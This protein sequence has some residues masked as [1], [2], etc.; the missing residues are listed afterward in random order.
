[1]GIEIE[2][3]RRKG[4]VIALAMLLG[5]V[6]FLSLAACGPA[7]AGPTPAPSPLPSCTPAPL[8]SPRP[9]L[10]RLVVS[11]N[12]ETSLRLR[13]AYTGEEV[14]H[15]ICRPLH[16]AVWSDLQRPAYLLE[17]S[18]PELGIEERREVPIYGPE[19]KVAL[20]FP[21]I[22]EIEPLPADAEVEVDGT[23]YHGAVRL[24]YPPE[25]CPYTATVWVRAGGYQ[26]YGVDL[27]I[28]AG[29]L[30]HREIGLQ[31]VPTAL[32]TPR[33]TAQTPRPPATPRPT[34]PTFTVEERVA[35]VRQKLYESF[36]C[37]RAEN[38]LP[39]LPYVIEWQAL[40]DDFARGWR[41]HYLSY[42]AS[43]FDSSP[44]RRQFQVV[45]GDA[46]PGGAGLPLHAPD[47]Y[48]GM[49]PDS[50]WETFNMCDPNCPQ[51]HYFWERT[52]MVRASGVVV[53]IAAWWDGD[54]LRG[55]VV[56]GFKW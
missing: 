41:D 48:V 30:R 56:I 39:P 31:P 9:A 26:T 46:V 43:G 35:L 29:T 4:G 18:C 7:T 34:A 33:P 1:M 27:R 45:G 15:G 5:V 53:G 12:A 11:C 42:G 19:E 40:A 54:I 24:T 37:I 36:N 32:P 8:P 17:V 22:L 23:T 28:E 2:R 10:A 25:Q 20:L 47:H 21:G 3:G 51:Y 50:R 49:A 14:H 6:L 52:E 55:S 16:E 38:G 13:D 44:W